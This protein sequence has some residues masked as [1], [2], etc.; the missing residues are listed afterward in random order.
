M[1]TVRGVHK[2]HQCRDKLCGVVWESGAWRAQGEYTEGQSTWL[3][4]GIREVF[5]GEVIFL[6]ISKMPVEFLKVPSGN[7]TETSGLWFLHQSVTLV[8][9]LTSLIF[10][11]HLEN[12]YLAYVRL[13]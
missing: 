2:E 11:A 4:L 8:W 1:G 13:L 6:L 3:A 10:K 7:V 5:P 12:D 9:V